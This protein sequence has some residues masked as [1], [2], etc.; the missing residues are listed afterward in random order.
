MLCLSK[1]IQK[2]IPTSQYT[3]HYA[4][5]WWA[6]SAN[7]NIFNYHAQTWC[8]CNVYRKQS[9]RVTYYSC[10]YLHTCTSH[11]N[12]VV[13]TN[14]PMFCMLMQIVSLNVCFV[15][16]AYGFISS[17]HSQ[18]Y[19]SSTQPRHLLSRQGATTAN[20]GN[21]TGEWLFTQ[22]LIYLLKICLS[23]NMQMLS[24]RAILR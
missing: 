14:L 10:E 24:M 4:I 18:K 3:V 7:T 17:L 12:L 19:R 15:T 1:A 13:R 16:L 22:K 23:R 5:V 11:Q 21:S 20:T 8:F 2:C 9:Q 6:E